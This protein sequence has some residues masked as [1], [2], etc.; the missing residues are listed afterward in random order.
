MTARIRLSYICKILLIV[1][2]LGGVLILLF[3]AN[4]DGF[5]NWWR[6]LLYFTSQSNIWIG[7][8]TIVLLFMPNES[9]FIARYV[10][11]VCIAMTGIVFSL[12]LSPFAADYGFQTWTLASIL[13]H[14]VAPILAVVDFFLDKRSF[15]LQ[16]KHVWL[17]ALPPIFYFSTSFLLVYFN[18][19]FGKG[20]PFPYFFMNFRSPVGLFGFSGKLP[21]IMGT[22]YWF[23]IFPSVLFII[24]VLLQRLKEKQ[25]KKLPNG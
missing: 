16:R 1:A 22:A 21:Y 12:L 14:A 7:I 20:M 8:T 4:R 13:T 10:F 24:G 2:S 9:T 17:C 3:T 25:L 15:P 11:T 19:D 23:I 18:V 6:R 5:S